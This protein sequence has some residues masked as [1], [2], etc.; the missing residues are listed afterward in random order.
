MVPDADVTGP[1][2]TLPR[3]L[4]AWT[5]GITACVAGHAILLAGWTPDLQESHSNNLWQAYACEKD[6]E[7]RDIDQ[8]A[9][10]WLGL[11]WGQSRILFH[12]GNNHAD[13]FAMLDALIRN[14]LPDLILTE[15]EALRDVRLRREQAELEAEADN[16]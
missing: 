8:V 6:D 4:E 5:C 10:E 12:S 1:E 2:F 11:T 13:V 16:A 9:R 7:W 3:H 14:D 15:L